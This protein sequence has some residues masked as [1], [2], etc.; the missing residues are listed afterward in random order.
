MY[1]L[2]DNEDTI[3]YVE[4]IFCNYFM[5]LDYTQYIQEEHL[6]IGYDA[7]MGNAWEAQK[8]REAY[9]DGF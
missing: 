9:N 8:M 5:N 4:M 7:T 6:P 2:S 1:A 3:I